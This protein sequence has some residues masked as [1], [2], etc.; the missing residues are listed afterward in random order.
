MQRFDPS[1]VGEGEEQQRAS[2]F[3][4]E[5]DSH[6]LSSEADYRLQAHSQPLQLTYHAVSS[7]PV[8]LPLIFRVFDFQETINELFRCFLPAR[9]HD[10]QA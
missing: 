2:L 10:L 6:P 9:Q 8:A 7:W 3:H 4:L 1:V 5:F